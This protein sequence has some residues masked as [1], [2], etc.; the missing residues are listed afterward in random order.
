MI[1]LYTYLLSCLI[2]AI[3]MVVEAIR[4]EQFK[5]QE[6]SERFIGL[7]AV[8]SLSFALYPLM[9]ASELEMTDINRRDF[10]MN[11]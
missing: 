5:I 11:E 1:L 6:N 8:F 10:Y 9:I 2:F 3:A 7:I 4:S